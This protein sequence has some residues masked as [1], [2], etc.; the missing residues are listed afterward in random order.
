MRPH[1][2]PDL[3]NRRSASGD[4]ASHPP[5]CELA[6]QRA[7]KLGT[8]PLGHDQAGVETDL[9]LYI[10]TA[11]HRLYRS[12]TSVVAQQARYGPDHKRRLSI[13]RSLNNWLART[14]NMRGTVFA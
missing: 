9:P 7:L 11:K 3:A 6:G 13:N 2:E 4:A 8:V 14:R 5:D 12:I 1:F 10:T